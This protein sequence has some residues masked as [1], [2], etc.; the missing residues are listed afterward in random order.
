[1]FFLFKTHTV[2]LTKGFQKHNTRGM[3]CPGKVGQP[4]A[5]FSSPPSPTCEV[6]R[7]SF[8]GIAPG[9]CCNFPLH[10]LL[11]ARWMVSVPW[12][13]RRCPR[14]GPHPSLP[15]PGGSPRR[16]GIP[17]SGWVVHRCGGPQMLYWIPDY[18]KKSRVN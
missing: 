14:A 3:R 13:P 8:L 16:G 7:T 1:M 2:L 4:P 9:S 11:S 18:C 15:P 17:D 12:G 5:I 10:V 6:C